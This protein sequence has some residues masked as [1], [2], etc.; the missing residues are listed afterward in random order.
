MA[1]PL[2]LCRWHITQLLYSVHANGTLLSPDTD[3]PPDAASVT[4]SVEAA[5]DSVAVFRGEDIVRGQEVIRQDYVYSLAFVGVVHS[6]ESLAN[7][8]T[9]AW[10]M[11]YG[12]SSPEKNFHRSTSDRPHKLVS[13]LRQ[14][15]IT[16]PYHCHCNVRN[17]KHNALKNRQGKWCRN[18]ET[19]GQSNLTKGRIVA[20]KIHDRSAL[21]KLEVVFLK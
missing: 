18:K 17:S 7:A 16:V 10:Q 20:P 8:L 2:V 14:S 19:R 3:D 21:T 12:M 4:R 11:S 15:T 9:T 6:R 13:L 1:E 5:V